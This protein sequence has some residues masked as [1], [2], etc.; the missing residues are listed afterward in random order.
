MAVSL[1]VANVTG[2]EDERIVPAAQ[3]LYKTFETK[4]S[5]ELYEAFKEKSPEVLEQ[6]GINDDNYV[7][8]PNGTGDYE[9]LWVSPFPIDIWDFWIN[10]RFNPGTARRYYSHENVNYIPLIT[11]ADDFIQ[12]PVPGKNVYDDKLIYLWDFIYNP[13]IL[14]G[15]RFRA[16]TATRRREFPV[17]TESGSISDESSIIPPYLPD[18][19]FPADFADVYPWAAW[20]VPLDVSEAQLHG[21][22]RMP[23]HA[24]RMQRQTYIRAHGESTLTSERSSD[25][26]RFTPHLATETLARVARPLYPIRDPSL[27]LGYYAIPYSPLV[28]RGMSP[29]RTNGWIRCYRQALRYSDASFSPKHPLWKYFAEAAR[30]YASSKPYSISFNYATASAMPAIARRIWGAELKNYGPKFVFDIP[31]DKEGSDEAESFLLVSAVLENMVTSADIYELAVTVAGPLMEID[32]FLV[33]TLQIHETRPQ[34]RQHVDFESGK[35]VLTVPPILSVDPPLQLDF[36][37][38]DQAIKWR[39][40]RNAASPV[41]AFDT[42]EVVSSHQIEV[43]SAE[44]GE[45][46]LMCEVI[47]TEY[48]S[49]RVVSTRYEFMLTWLDCRSMVISIDHFDVNAP[50]PIY[51]NIRRPLANYWMHRVADESLFAYAGVDEYVKNYLRET[52]PRYEVS[53]AWQRT[54]YLDLVATIDFS[55]PVILVRDADTN[56]TLNLFVVKLLPVKIEV[57]CFGERV[58]LDLAYDRTVNE[59]SWKTPQNQLLSVQEASQLIFNVVVPQHLGV[60]TAEIR[61]RNSSGLPNYTVSFSVELR[62]TSSVPYD[63]IQRFSVEEFEK[64][65]KWERNNPAVTYKRVSGPKGDFELVCDLRSDYTGLFYQKMI[66][67]WAYNY[68]VDLGNYAQYFPRV[69]QYCRCMDRYV[70]QFTKVSNRDVQIVDRIDANVRQFLPKHLSEPVLQLVLLAQD[71]DAIESHFAFV[72]FDPWYS[73]WINII[74]IQPHQSSIN[75]AWLP[76]HMKQFDYIHEEIRHLYP[77]VSVEMQFSDT[78]VERKTKDVPSERWQLIRQD[79]VDTEALLRQLTFDVRDLDA[80][81]SRIYSELPRQINRSYFEHIE[82][83]RDHIYAELVLETEE[84]FI[85]MKQDYDSYIRYVS[86]VLYQCLRVRESIRTSTTPKPAAW[87]TLRRCTFDLWKLYSTDRFGFRAL[88]DYIMDETRLSQIENHHSII[89]TMTFNEPDDV[90]FIRKL[91]SSERVYDEVYVLRAF[92][93]FVARNFAANEANMKMLIDVSERKIRKTLGA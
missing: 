18:A 68:A 82:D 62:W 25:A 89:A 71:E 11:N 37:K 61:A 39:V 73:Q 10:Y 46:P 81:I 51:K 66:N 36:Y 12:P 4:S 41:I 87:I 56:G 19:T 84:Q 20:E 35:F 54:T 22:L 15:R 60:Y 28:L 78:I 44:Y 64:Y 40:I 21:D 49:K 16:K 69:L 65:G 80:N 29:F 34:R 59:V 93:V 48:Q 30:I 70:E 77:F 31:A 3:T 7:R 1:T 50:L 75:P 8:E 43:T 83:A 14:T 32:P 76:A 90:T 9:G 88:W 38:T 45:I 52:W 86:N 42:A 57:P 23:L 79:Y 47:Y 33:I 2:L 67:A 91:L 58:L 53:S 72:I 24:I 85:K 63:F 27:Y 6:W 5:K 92:I 17:Y 13:E 74:A 26:Y 55:R